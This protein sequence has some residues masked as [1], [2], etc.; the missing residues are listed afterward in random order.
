M[1]LQ[2]DESPRSKEGSPN[3]RG[4]APLRDRYAAFEWEN[5][6]GQD[7][8]IPDPPDRRSGSSQECGRS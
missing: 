7:S 8:S 5:W 6:D 3:A 1:R 4:S 2:P